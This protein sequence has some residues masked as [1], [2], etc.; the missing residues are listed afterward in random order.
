MGGRTGVGSG[1]CEPR[2]EFIVKLKRK[3]GGGLSGGCDPIIE[4]IEYSTACLSVKCLV[5]SWVDDVCVTVAC[6]MNF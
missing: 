3:G 2:I 5:T 6:W 4:A 1:G